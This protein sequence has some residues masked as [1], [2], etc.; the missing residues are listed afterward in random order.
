MPKHSTR[1]RVFGA[2]AA[3]VGAAAVGVVFAAPANA[4]VFSVAITTPSGYGSTAGSYGTGC[5]YEVEVKTTSNAAVTYTIAGPT[6]SNGTVT[7]ENG[8]ASFDFAPTAR[9]TY[10]I[11]AVQGDGDPGKSVTATVGGRGI[12]LPNIPWLNTIGTNG[13]CL[14]LP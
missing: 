3:L 6:T 10:R 4:A 5:S 1:N 8:V 7:P 11:T 14:V 13:A 9:G 12:Q 2:S